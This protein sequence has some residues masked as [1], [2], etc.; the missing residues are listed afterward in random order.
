MATYTT[1]GGIKKISTGDESGTWGTSTN[2]NFDIIDR[3][4]A[5]VGDITL[6]GT[7]HTLTTSDGSTSDGQFHVLKLGG[8]PSGTNTITISPNDTKRMYMVQNASGQ[9][10]TFSQG[11]G[12]NVSVSNG[13]SAII[14]C[15]GAGSGAAVVDLGALLPSTT[16]L[17]DLSV[18][19]T[20]SE[21]NIMDGVTSTTA[22]LNILDGVTATATELNILD[23]VTATTAELNLMDGGTTV[24]TTAVSDGDGIVTNDG[25]TMRQTNVTTFA[26]YFADEITSMSNLVTTGALNSGSITS[27]FGSINNGSSAITT[28]GTVTEGIVDTSAGEL[29]I[30]PVT[31]EGSVDTGTS[32]TINVDCDSKGVIFFTANQTANRTINFRGDGSTTLNSYMDT[33]DVITISLMM[34]QGSSAYYLN[35][36]QIDGSSVTPEW[37]GGTA[38]SAGNANSI[39]VYTV[40]IFKTAS[41]T[42]TVLASQVQYA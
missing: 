8:S 25:G 19:A 23:G 36:F 5:G 24:G 22:E 33:N 9:T 31:E 42:F 4:V 6:S 1:N 17:S 21:L 27:G 32:G 29:K 3:L 18:T 12:A 20:A 28:T 26:T 34:K 10:A 11:S 40:T 13:K 14:Y 35:A 30:T 38:P 2:T 7:T 39:D 15:D 37:Q 16:T 41:A